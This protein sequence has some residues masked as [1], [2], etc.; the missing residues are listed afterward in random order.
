MSE[1]PENSE[2]STVATNLI[3]SLHNKQKQRKRKSAKTSGL[4]SAENANYNP[5]RT[6]IIGGDS[7]DFEQNVPPAIILEKKNDQISKILVKCPCGRH[8]E[9]ICEYEDEEDSE[10]NQ[11]PPDAQ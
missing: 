10:A 7:D 3:V 9:L 4:I 5:N 8:A 1:T 11:L 2:E 6:R